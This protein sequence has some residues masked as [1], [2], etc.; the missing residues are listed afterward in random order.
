MFGLD[1]QCLPGGCVATT[2]LKRLKGSIKVDRLPDASSIAWYLQHITK[3]AYDAE[4]ADYQTQDPQ[5]KYRLWEVFVRNAILVQILEKKPRNRRIEFYDEGVLRGYGI[6]KVPGRKKGQPDQEFDEARLRLAQRADG[7]YRRYCERHPHRSGVS[8]RRG[9]QN[10]PVLE[11]KDASS[12]AILYEELFIEIDQS[13]YAIKRCAK[14]MID[15]KK[16]HKHSRNPGSK[17]APPTRPAPVHCRPGASPPESSRHDVAPPVAP[18]QEGGGS[19]SLSSDKGASSAK[20]RR[21]SS[22]ASGQSAAVPSH[23]G[24]RKPTQ[25]LSNGAAMSSESPHQQLT[26][27]SESSHRPAASPTPSPRDP[28]PGSSRASFSRYTTSS[29]ASSRVSSRAP[30]HAPS[31]ALIGNRASSLASNERSGRSPLPYPDGGSNGEGQPVATTNDYLS[32]GSQPHLSSGSDSRRAAGDQPSKAVPKASNKAKSAE[33]NSQRPSGHGSS[34]IV[35]SE[36]SND[37]ERATGGGNSSSRGS[38]STTTRISKGKELAIK[39]E[40]QR[41]ADSSKPSSDDESDIES[42]S[43]W[44]SDGGRGL[45]KWGDRESLTWKRA[46]GERK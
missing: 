31:D 9:L 33:G 29:T 20:G 14:S 4:Q 32:V 12:P 39:T 34:I 22:R 37:K 13:C 21:G 27:R 15:R 40:T 30:S 25:G 44:H 24:S 18:L 45:P 28:S 36:R 5:A 11:D 6:R 35:S 3:E 43:S 41:A 23:G 7:E 42:I 16:G 2:L 19:L 17:A 1:I 26:R 46:S 38:N 8:R 10:D